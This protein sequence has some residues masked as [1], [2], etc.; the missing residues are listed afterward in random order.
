MTTLVLVHVHQ[1]W[2]GYAG[3]RDAANKGVVAGRI[4]GYVQE[5]DFASGRVQ[6]VPIRHRQIGT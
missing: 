2:P 6:F 5:H 4:M 3:V 1:E